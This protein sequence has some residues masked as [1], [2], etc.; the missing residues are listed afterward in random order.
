MNK[1]LRKEL[2]ELVEAC[3]VF[4]TPIERRRHW[5]EY[6]EDAAKRLRKLRDKLCS[7]PINCVEELAMKMLGHLK[8]GKTPSEIARM[9]DHEDSALV[10]D[11]L[12]E[13]QF[14]NSIDELGLNDNNW[15]GSGHVEDTQ[16]T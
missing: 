1:Q 10:G 8:K 7:E 3:G 16:K 2:K 5:N 4:D 11:A 6:K 13:A 15:E 9:Y 14:Q 12:V